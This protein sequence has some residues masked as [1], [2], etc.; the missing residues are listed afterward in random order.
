MRAICAA[1]D[2]FVVRRVFERWQ[3]RLNPMQLAAMLCRLAELR[4]TTHAHTLRSERTALRRFT[5]ALLL[6]ARGVL[7]SADAGTAAAM[8]RGMA[9][10]SKAGKVRG[11]Q[12]RVRTGACAAQR[13]CSLLQHSG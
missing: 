1:P 5:A 3:G 8:L 2:W 13:G 10:L 7:P 6:E 11:S 9:Q 12:Q 4:A